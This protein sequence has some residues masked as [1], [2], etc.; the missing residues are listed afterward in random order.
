MCGRYALY[1]TSKA[2]FKIPH[3]LVG[4][5]YNIAPSTTVPVVVKNNQVMLITWTF[6]SPWIGDL[7][8]IN[9]RSETL[10]TKKIFRGAKRCIFLA[11]GYYEWLRRD[12]VRIPYYHTFKDRMMYFGGIF[13]E[14]GGCIVTRQSYPMKV[15]VHHR[16]PVIL[17]YT[18]FTSWFASDHDFSCEHSR[19][20]TIY[21]VSR[22]VN[23]SKNNSAGNIN[24]F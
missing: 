22:D 8:I 2:D 17:R 11:N 13:N 23:S 19:D 18:E 5:N 16:Q 3:N 14:T 15:E 24:R 10:E 6:K 20:M 1:D 4:T 9:A 12:K 7:N 21:E